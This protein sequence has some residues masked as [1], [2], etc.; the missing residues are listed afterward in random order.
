VK[1]LGKYILLTGAR[2][3]A[4]DFL[5]TEKSILLMQE[6]IKDFDYELY[7]RQYDFNNKLD[8][9]NQSKGIILL[10]GPS[11]RQKIYPDI[12]KLVDDLDKI[13]VP[14]IALGIGCHFQTINFKDIINFKFD[15]NSMK[16]I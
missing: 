4:G 14:I 11:I 9:L 2:K 7:D 12:Y 1:I 10:G 8:I 15:S 3:N 13:K 6:L 5:I 16:L